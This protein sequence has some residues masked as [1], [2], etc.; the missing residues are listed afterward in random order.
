LQAGDFVTTGLDAN[1]EA[2]IWQVKFATQE[3]FDGM[4]AALLGQGR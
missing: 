2:G 4:V 3:N 1:R